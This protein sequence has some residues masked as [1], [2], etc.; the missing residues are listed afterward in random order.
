[1]KRIFLISTLLLL[2]AGVQAQEIQ[3]TDS[4]AA[5]EKKESKFVNAMNNAGE[6]IV[7][8]DTETMLDSLDQEKLPK[9]VTGGLFAGVNMSDFIITRAGQTMISHRRVGAELGGFIDFALTKHFAIQPQVIFT[10]HQNYFSAKDDEI[11]LVNDRLWSFGMEIP[12]YFLGR[13]GNMQQ[14]YVQF[15]GGI[16]THFTFASNIGTYKS[17]DNAQI[18]PTGE[19]QGD[20]Q[21]TDQ[22]KDG[23]SYTSLYSLHNNHFGVCAT[24]G[25]ECT[26][27]MQINIQYKISLS[28]IAGFYSSNKGTEIA[29]ALIYPHSLSLCIGYRFK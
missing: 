14:G 22:E 16:F 25:Y 7:K 13:F 12:V 20:T 2:I 6:A 15:G 1:M 26:F 10:A 3:K 23:Y 28:D 9:K 19:P 27:G 8:W 11:K 18:T 21:E 17:T 29:N 4:T 24:V 5:S